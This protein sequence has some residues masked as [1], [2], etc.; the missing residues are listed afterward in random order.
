MGAEFD[1]SATRQDG[2]LIGITDRRETVRNGDRGPAGAQGVDRL[3]NGTLGPV[4][5]GGRGFVQ[6]QHPGIA[7]DR[8]GNGQTLLLTAGEAMSAGTDH[9]VETLGQP[10]DQVGNLGCPESSPHLRLARVGCG[11]QEVGPNGVVHEVGLL[12]HD[13]DDRGQILLADRREWDA[14]DRDRAGRGVTQPRHQAGQGRL[15]RPR[16]TDERE[17]RSGRNVERDAVDRGGCAIGIREGDAVEADLATHPRTVDRNGRD[18]SGHIGHQVEVAED[19]AEERHRGDPR[20]AD[21]EQAHERPEDPCLQAGEGH[22][23]ADRHPTAGSWEACREVNERRDGGEDDRHRR[24]PPAARERGAKLQIDQLGGRPLEAVAGQPTGP[25][26]LGQKHPT[27]RQP[28]VDLDVQI[29]QAS[30]QG[31]GDLSAQQRYAPRQP[32]RRREDEE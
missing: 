28:L 23:R 21:V 8:A 25:Q 27:D 1:H 32:D 12:R 2:D 17:A 16:V 10:S 4:V 31:G 5:E 7:Q 14:V 30:L 6:D 24:H 29:G 22:Q 9:G 13:A 26:G 3:L 11:Q 19:P 20:D 15:A 18:R